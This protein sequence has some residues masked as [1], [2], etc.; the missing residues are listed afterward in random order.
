MAEETEQVATEDTETPDGGEVDYK[1]LYEAEKAH[2]REWERRAKANKS[3]AD[4]LARAQEAGK[5]AE[6]RIA[7]LTRRL[8]EKE[9]AEARAKVAARVAAAKGVPA[10][11]FDF[12]RGG[13]EEE[14]GEWA[15]RVRS[16]FAPRVAPKVERPGTFAKSDGKP[17]D[18]GMRDV[19]RKLFPDGK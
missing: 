19:I 15:D 11:V 13:T 1:A 16:A 10:E 5:T 2:K 17:D 7:E 4:E 9:R 6:E 12:P 3:A 18:D 8:D 14:M